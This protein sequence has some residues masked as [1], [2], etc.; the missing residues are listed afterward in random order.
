MMVMAE[1]GACR[2]AGS[3]CGALLGL[4]NVGFAGD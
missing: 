3:S 2:C 4:L 1:R